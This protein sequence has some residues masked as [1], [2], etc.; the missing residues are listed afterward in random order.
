MS[1][2]E[3]ERRR[4]EKIMQKFCDE[5]GPPSHIHNKLKW[6]YQ[7]DPEKQTVI[8]FEV[9]PHFQD[10]DLKIESSIAKAKYIK[11]QKIWKIYWMRASGKWVSYEPHPLAKTLEEF[12]DVVKEDGYGCFFG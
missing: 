9:R 4:Y 6:G 7:V 3:F 11:S 10:P 5:K 8:F 2:S 12:L 1:I